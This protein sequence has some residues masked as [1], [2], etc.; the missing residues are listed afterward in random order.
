MLLGVAVVAGG[1]AALAPGS[2]ATTQP[3]HPVYTADFPDP[4][5]LYHGGR[6]YAF[7]T[8]TDERNV[9]GAV[10][11]DGLHWRS[12][13]ADALPSLPGW[14]VPGTPVADD[15]KTWAPS[16]IYN[17]TTKRFVMFYAALD[18]DYSPPKHCIGKAV[19]RTAAGPYRDT[20]T[21]PFL[22]QPDLGGTIDPDV[23][24]NPNTGRAFL[25]VKNAGNA[26]GLPDYIWVQRLTATFAATGPLTRLLAVDQPW[27]GRTIE[28]PTMSKF[29]GHFF[30]L[31]AGNTYTTR[32]YAIGYATCRTPYGP[33]TDNPANPLIA[34]S[35]TMRGPG[36][37][38]FFTTPRGVHKIVF[39]AWY[40]TVKSIRAMYQARLTMR[41]GRLR[42][43][44]T[45]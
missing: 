41:N 21:T 17:P 19:S 12:T 30:L 31:Y 5:V 18:N 10:S 13:S 45:H 20:S 37:P 35:G 25:Y 23:Y 29:R 28:G 24:I 36:S 33:C 4:T 42:V 44:A 9:N 40:R 11:T 15:G 34:T 26:A 3:W 2:A 1:F 43:A 22:C 8:Q 6:Y 16:V 27:Q 7:A 32:R 38:A 14:V 39:A